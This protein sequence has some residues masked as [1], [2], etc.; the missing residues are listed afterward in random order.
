MANGA[1]R[2]ARI[3]IRRRMTRPPRW[4]S[5]SPAATWAAGYSSGN[6]TAL[7]RLMGTAA[8][9]TLVGRTL[10]ILSLDMPGLVI[11]CGCCTNPFPSTR[12]Y[13]ERLSVSR[14]WDEGPLRSGGVIDRRSPLH[15]VAA[16]GSFQTLFVESQVIDGR[17]L[18]IR[19]R[20]HLTNRAAT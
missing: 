7:Q 14:L 8:T 3:V 13:R 15:S 18:G 17:S 9:S 4:G 19:H 6:T 10:L 16:Q 20:H 2:L 1:L 11:R 5:F 12:P